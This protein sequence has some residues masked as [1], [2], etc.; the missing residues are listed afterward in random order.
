[1]N[2]KNNA[3]KTLAVIV[4]LLSVPAFALQSSKTVWDGVYTDAQ[5]TRGQKTYETRCAGCHELS[6]FQGQEFLDNWKGKTVSDLFDDISSAMPMDSPGSLDKQVYMDVITYFMK[7]NTMPAGS[8]DLM[9]EKNILQGIQFTDKP[10]VMPAPAAGG[11]EAAPADMGNKTGTVWD[12]VY[13]QDQAARGKNT[14]DMSC[15][16]CHELGNFTGPDFLNE[17]N[18]MT[19]G[20]L[21]DK[22]SSS[23]PMDNPGSLDKQVY[24][25]VITYFFQLNEFPTGGAELKADPDALKAI[26]IAPKPLAA[27]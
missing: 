20:D 17:W 14:F 9:P 5:A 18:G 12:G 25:D 7:L 3:L 21:F 23:M 8:A 1:M 13:T 6:N 2:N 27:H 19:A 11:A 10:E 15:A 22:V 4:V 24:V 16:G 26:K